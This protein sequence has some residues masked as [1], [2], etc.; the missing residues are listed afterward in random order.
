[1]ST[2]GSTNGKAPQTP[3]KK[4]GRPCKLTPEVHE[5][6]VEALSSGC[7]RD[8]AAQ[9][10]GIHVATFYRWIETGEADIE[11]GRE[12]PYRDLC[13]A[14]TRA[15]AE[16]FVWHLNNMRRH[17]VSDFRAS[18]WFLERK[19]PERFGK[20][21]RMDMKVSGQ[22]DLSSALEAAREFAAAEERQQ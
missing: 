18:G 7:Y 20:R 5:R 8:T 19:D 10:V 9:A 12:S 13:E 17:A 6:L 1:M 16:G 2:N 11:Q 3:R 4:R 22:L 14:L 21:E 15:E